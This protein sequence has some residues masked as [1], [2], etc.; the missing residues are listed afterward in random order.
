M[1]VFCEY[2]LIKRNGD[3]WDPY[4]SLHE[5]CDKAEHDEDCILDASSQLTNLLPLDVDEVLE[6]LL[7]GFLR[8]GLNEDEVKSKWPPT[9]TEAGGVVGR[10]K[11][12]ELCPGLVELIH[13]G[14]D[15]KIDW[16]SVKSVLDY[17]W[18]PYSEASPEGDLTDFLSH[19]RS[20]SPVE[21]FRLV[22]NFS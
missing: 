21:N 15:P 6:Y 19:L 14:M 8:H 10:C 17:D 20:L 9:L 2:Y 5:E 13:D 7:A 3:S 4:L 18:G 11:V 1:S 12:S 16:I 22:I